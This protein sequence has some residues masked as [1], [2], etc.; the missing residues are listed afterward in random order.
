MTND[1]NFNEERQKHFFYEKIIT[2]YTKYNEPYTEVNY[3][4]HYPRTAIC[5]IALLFTIIGIFTSFSII[6]T[7]YTGVRST[8]GQISEEVVPAG[9]NWKVPYGIQKIEK[10]NN[11]QQDISF[12]ERIWSETKER[13]PVF[14]ENV[15]ITYS[16]NPNMSAWIYANVTDYRNTTISRGI[17]ASAIKSASKT[18]GDADAVNR[19]LIEPLSMTNLQAALDKKY[20]ENVITINQL[21]I[22]NADYEDSYNKALSEK[23]TAQLAA[24]KQEIE[25]KKAIEKAEADAKVAKTKAEADAAVTRTKAQA[26][27]DSTVTK[28][29]AE[30]K[31]NK[32]IEKSLTEEILREQY[33]NKWDG[34]LPQYM[35]GDDTSVLMEMK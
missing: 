8:F 19:A 23:Q 15:T 28:A 20:G 33:I 16:I 27:A 12:G 7:G 11:K 2:T 32:M 3:L 10:V 26:S 9:F 1:P 21:I 35:L 18:F 31:A 24:E 13:T 4:I 30:A 22:N 34:K 5:A 17:V 25:N 6:P 29:E 14:Y